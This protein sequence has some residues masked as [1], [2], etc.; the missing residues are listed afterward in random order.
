MTTSAK[1]AILTVHNYDGEGCDDDT[2]IHPFASEEA[3][4]QE[5][6]AFIKRV[7]GEDDEYSINIDRDCETI[8]DINEALSREDVREAIDLFNDLDFQTRFKVRVRMYNVK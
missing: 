5:C 8:K 6:A 7:L 3:A 4:L 2:S 1:I